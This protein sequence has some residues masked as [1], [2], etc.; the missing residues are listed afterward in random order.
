MRE[1]VDAPHCTRKGDFLPRHLLENVSPKASS[2]HKHNELDFTTHQRSSKSQEAFRR[3][4]QSSLKTKTSRKSAKA[5]KK[6]SMQK[7]TSK[8]NSSKATKNKENCILG[9]MCIPTSDSREDIIM[10]SDFV[11]RP[12]CYNKSP[13]FCP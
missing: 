3:H 6:D 7:E 11:P 10:P 8:N 2:K 1:D 9:I 12:M 13:I 4:Q 5:K